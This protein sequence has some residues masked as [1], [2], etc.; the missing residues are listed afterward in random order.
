MSKVMRN[1]EKLMSDGFRWGKDSVEIGLRADKI[2]K[3]STRKK[4]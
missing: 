4:R 2:L 3:L 1:T